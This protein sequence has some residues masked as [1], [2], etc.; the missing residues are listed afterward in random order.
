MKVCEPT[1]L[2]STL[3]PFRTGPT[4]DGT[5]GHLYRAASTLPCEYVA[6]STGAE[7]TGCAGGAAVNV[8]ATGAPSPEAIGVS[9]PAKEP[10]SKPPASVH[11]TDSVYGPVGLNFFVS[12]VNVPSGFTLTLFS[13]VPLPIVTVQWQRAA[14]ERVE[15]G[16]RDRE[17]L[18]R[19]R[20]VLRGGHHRTG[21]RGA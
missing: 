5:F 10:T 18:V 20:V 16:S 4:H 14:P 1:V 7:I 6:P 13:T 12:S 19:A 9:V 17:G 11:D 8:R 21:R 2:V 15:T 3:A